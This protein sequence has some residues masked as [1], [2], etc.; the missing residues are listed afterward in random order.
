MALSQLIFIEKS[1]RIFKYHPIQW[2]FEW[3]LHGLLS[4]N[5]LSSF[6]FF[7]WTQSNRPGETRA[8]EPDLS[9]PDFTQLHI[10]ILS[11]G[12]PVCLF[13]KVFSELKRWKYF[14]K[15]FICC[16]F[17]YLG[18]FTLYYPWGE[19]TI[20]IFLFFISISLSPFFFFS[21]IF[22]LLCFYV[23]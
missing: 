19:W 12:G 6:S 9:F 13:R 17:I 20:F 1:Q 4:H 14:M 8:Q 7:F 5:I 15:V 3:N 10:W 23:F 16:P 11:E 18:V 21:S 2:Q 22:F